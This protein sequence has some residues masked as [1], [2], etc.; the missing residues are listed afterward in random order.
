VRIAVHQSFLFAM[1]ASHGPALPAIASQLV[2]A[3]QQ[4]DSDVGRMVDSWPDLDHYQDVSAQ[5]ELIRMYCSALDEA[6]VQWV[7]L[8]ITHAELVH[9]LWRSQYGHEPASLA[10]IESVR[11]RHGDCVAALRGRCAR[12]IAR[13]AQHLS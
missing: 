13:S 7:E 2:A 6:R 5:I 3:L 4:Y 1:S 9:L 11:D 8:L 12:V 10:Q